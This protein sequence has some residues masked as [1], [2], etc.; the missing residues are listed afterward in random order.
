MKYL[1]CSTTTFAIAVFSLLGLFACSI[2][3]ATQTAPDH[4]DT[5]GETTSEKA[6]AVA[7]VPATNVIVTAETQFPPGTVGKNW[8]KPVEDSPRFG[9][10]LVDQLEYRVQEGADTLDWDVTGWYGGDYN[11]LWLKSEG[12]W[13]TSGERGGE[14][15][16]I[17]S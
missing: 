13:R 7:G 16:A 8:P 12:G 9:F 17:A 4:Q 11:R 6:A 1:P 5:H 15:D 10:L 14:F 2:G 3:A